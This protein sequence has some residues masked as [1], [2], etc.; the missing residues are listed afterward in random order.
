MVDRPVTLRRNVRRFQGSD[1]H[2]RPW[3]SSETCVDH[4]KWT[5][6][7][8]DHVRQECLHGFRDGLE[9]GPAGLFGHPEDIVGAVFVLVFRRLIVLGQELGAFGLKG[10]GDLFKEDEAEDDVLVIGRLQVLAQLV[11]R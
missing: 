3:E 4:V 10:V 7:L 11:G 1:C 9:A 8:D 6:R 5:E 2:D